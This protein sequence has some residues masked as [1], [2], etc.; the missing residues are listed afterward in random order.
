M[1]HIG[2]SIVVD[3]ELTTTEPLQLDGRLR[4]QIVARD[5]EITIG[6]SAVVDADVRG[7]RVTVLG[8]LHGNIVATERIELGPSAD[9]QGSLSANLVVIAD[10]ARFNGGIDMSQRTIAA[11]VAEYRASRA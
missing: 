5:T 6:P 1:T 10:G 4:G 2:A 8:R 3:G 7:T 9:V 11:K